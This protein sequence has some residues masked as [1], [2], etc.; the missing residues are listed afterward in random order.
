MPTIPVR[1][2]LFVSSYFPLWIIF[3]L[4][5]FE[6]HPLRAVVIAGAGVVTLLLA[7]A[8]M[9]WGRRHLPPDGA[10]LL[11]FT[12][13]DS[14]VMSYIA[15]YL[16]PFVS[17]SFDSW[18]QMIALALFIIV[19]LIIYVNSNMIYIN[20]MLNLFGYHFYEIKI[21][22]SQRSFYYL[23]RKRLIRD[24]KID[25]VYVSDDILLER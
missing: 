7:V 3:G 5:L 15:T 25:Y 13:R 8:Y 20:P 24:D 18:L 4:L 1:V 22:G 23:A 9:L 21:E 17:F 11:E 6:K 16:I 19:L 14:E 2:L 10:K 12:R